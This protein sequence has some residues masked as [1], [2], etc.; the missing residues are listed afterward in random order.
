MNAVARDGFR[1]WTPINSHYV[2]PAALRAAQIAQSKATRNGKVAAF[3]LQPTDD[4]THS[5]ASRR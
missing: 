3:Q 2:D 4:T 1:K 5:H